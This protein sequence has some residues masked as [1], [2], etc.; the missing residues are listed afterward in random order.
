MLG[1]VLAWIWPV[2]ARIWLSVLV[3]LGQDFAGC[4]PGFWP[5]FSQEFCWVFAGILPCVSPG[6]CPCVAHVFYQALAMIWRGVW[7]G[8]G[9]A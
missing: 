1:L 3:G 7:P 6:F 4:F 2:L 5:G 8:F 9:S